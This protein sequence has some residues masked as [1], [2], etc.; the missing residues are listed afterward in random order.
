MWNVK[1]FSLQ[2]KCDVYFSGCFYWIPSGDVVSIIWCSSVFCLSYPV[3]PVHNDQRWM[4]VANTDRFF[5]LNLFLTMN[6][7]NPWYTGDTLDI[8]ERFW[9]HAM[10]LINLLVVRPWWTWTNADGLTN[11]DRRKYIILMGSDDMTLFFFLE[12][13]H[14]EF[15][16]SFLSQ[17]CCVGFCVSINKF[18]AFSIRSRLL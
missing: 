6:L 3:A 5:C 9:C 18:M 7:W 13:K 17:S 16:K 2:V 15:W 12:I 4:V 11:Y 14:S 10:A 8:F 1:I